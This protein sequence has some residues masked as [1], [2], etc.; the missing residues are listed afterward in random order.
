MRATAHPPNTHART[1]R[2]ANG[3][4]GGVRHELHGVGELVDLV[5]EFGAAELG[6]ALGHEVIRHLV[7]HDLRGGGKGV[8]WGGVGWGGAGRK[9]RGG[10]EGTDGQYAEEES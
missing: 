1:P 10:K 3:R 5:P 7:A 4:E 2:D 6:G 9:E 8:G